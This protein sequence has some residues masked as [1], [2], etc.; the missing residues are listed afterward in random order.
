M[1]LARD[2]DPCIRWLGTG[3]SGKKLCWPAFGSC[4]SPRGIALVTF[5]P[6][7]VIAMIAVYAR[8]CAEARWSYSSKQ[9]RPQRRRDNFY[10][11]IAKSFSV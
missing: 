3:G 8:V 2:H 9:I 5:I 1:M 10:F 11:A 4:Q 6:L 7:R